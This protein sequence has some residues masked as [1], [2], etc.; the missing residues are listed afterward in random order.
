MGPEEPGGWRSLYVSGLFIRRLRNPKTIAAWLKRFSDSPDPLAAAV[1]YRRVAAVKQLH[2]MW[3]GNSKKALL[4][5]FPSMRFE[6]S[7]NGAT[8]YGILGRTKVVRLS[9]HPHH[10]NIIPPPIN[11]ADGKTPPDAIVAAVQAALSS[12]EPAQNA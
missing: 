12:S 9:N 3:L 5:A 7:R 1:E 6:M 4:D 11:I 10:P 8:Y 2:A